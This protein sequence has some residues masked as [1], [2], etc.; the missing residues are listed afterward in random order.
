[1][2]CTVCHV[3][4]AG[5]SSGVP[6]HEVKVTCFDCLDK[7]RARSSDDSHTEALVALSAT[8]AKERGVWRAQMHE[9]TSDVLVA[10]DDRPVAVG[11]VLTC[12]V[13]CRYPYLGWTDQYRIR[14]I[15]P[16]AKTALAVRQPG[17][18]ETDDSASH[19]DPLHSSN[20][21]YFDPAALP[22]DYWPRTDDSQIGDWLH[23]HL[24]E[25][26]PDHQKLEAALAEQD[27]FGWGWQTYCPKDPEFSAVILKHFATGKL[28]NAVIDIVGFELFVFADEDGGVLLECL[29][30]S[31]EQH[32]TIDVKVFVSEAIRVQVL[33]RFVEVPIRQR[34][35]L[36]MLRPHMESEWYHQEVDEVVL[37][38][39]RKGAER[40]CPQV[41][42]P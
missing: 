2:L 26:D 31:L 24:L 22:P 20:F 15:E 11:D 14:E 10:L 8:T 21:R 18:S 42:Q 17:T 33:H 41:L 23:S 19:E 16:T 6:T 13:R 34:V 3:P 39:E 38:A 36:E 30:S 7:E 4:V 28:E 35:W 29:E 9:S 12:E 37:K 25:D 40:I 1:M 32:P 5:I 27:D